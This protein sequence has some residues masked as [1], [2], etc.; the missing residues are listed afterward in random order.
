MKLLRKRQ[1]S[2]VRAQ[3]LVVKVQDSIEEIINPESFKISFI[4]AY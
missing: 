3:D 2:V 4:P 1:E